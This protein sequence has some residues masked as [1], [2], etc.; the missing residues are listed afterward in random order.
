[1][2][3]YLIRHGDPDYPTN[4]LTLRGMFQAEAVGKR[5]ADAGIDRIF[6]SPMGRARLTA[7]PAARLTGLPIEI[8][9]WTHEIGKEKNT[10]FP[11]GKRK[12]ISLVPNIYLREN[13]AWDIPYDQT[14]TAPGFDTIAEKIRPTFDYIDQ[15]GRDFLERLGYREENG[16]YRILQPTHERVALFCHAAFMR[17]WL[18]TLLHIP[19]HMMWADFAITHTG[20]TVLEFRHHKSGF[21]APKCLCLSD[22]SHLYAAGMDT[23]YDNR[24][25]L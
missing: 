20:V 21:T 4:T 16:V 3:L 22:I 23:V 7:S 24:I 18:S 11:D 13:G 2:L 8:E 17:A 25:R 10:T 1:M 6:S 12:S 19:K 5:M 15:S 14:L 9:E